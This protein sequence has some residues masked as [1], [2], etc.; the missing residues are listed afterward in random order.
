MRGGVKTCS[1]VLVAASISTAWMPIESTR[2]QRTKAI[3]LNAERRFA[4]AKTNKKYGSDSKIASIHEERLKTAGRV[5]TKR[6][7]DPCKVF[8]GNLPFN[9]DDSQL[10][11]F[12]LKTMGQSKVV[13]HS[14]KVIYDWKTGK[15]KGYGFVQFIDPIYATVC[16]DQCSGKLLGGR[17]LSVS[18]GKKKEQENELYLKKK[19]NKPETEEEAVISSALDE[20]ESDEEI[21]VFGGSDEDLELDAALFGIVGDD[22]DGEDDGVFLESR[23]RYDDDVDPNLN[24]EQRREAARRLKRKKLPSKGFG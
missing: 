6:Y 16:M 8:V 12:I 23:S 21:P 11:T 24:R 15:S 20:A 18:Q 17:P 3:S 5:G 2:T 9:V 7:V 4:Q 14:S 22:D 1:L 13:L 19:K 10:E